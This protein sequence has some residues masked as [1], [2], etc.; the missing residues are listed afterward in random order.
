MAIH[1]K[2]IAGM[3]FAGLIGLAPVGTANAETPARPA[4]VT[5]TGAVAPLVSGGGCSAPVDSGFHWTQDACIGWNGSQMIGASD[6]TFIAG[7]NR[8]HVVSC[9]WEGTIVSSYGTATTYDIDCTDLAHLGGAWTWT[10][11]LGPGRSVGDRYSWH[12]CMTVTT[13][14]VYDSCNGPHPASPMLTR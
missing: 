5:V 2:L 4:G 7:F 13:S 14:V 10:Q 8:G 12:T 3:F 11:P 6:T 1:R 9:T